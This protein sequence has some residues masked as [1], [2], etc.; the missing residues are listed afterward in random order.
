MHGNLYS[1]EI[2]GVN[3]VT[4]FQTS[5]RP[6]QIRQF[7][8]SALISVVVTRRR[9]TIKLIVFHCTTKRIDESRKKANDETT[10]EVNCKTDCEMTVFARDV[11]NGILNFGYVSVFEKTAS[12]VRFC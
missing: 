6:D 12:S 2:D 11:R 5:I 1:H 8:R 7:V 4:G 3:A 9:T 10:H